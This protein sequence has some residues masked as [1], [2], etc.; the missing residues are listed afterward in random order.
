[1]NSDPHS[2]QNSFMSSTGFGQ[3]SMMAAP[4][5]DQPPPKITSARDAFVNVEGALIKQYGDA[6]PKETVFAPGMS[7][8]QL[9]P[10]TTNMET[11]LGGLVPG[12]MPLHES[13]DPS[14]KTT[15]YPAADRIGKT[16]FMNQQ[17]M[18]PPQNW[19]AVG[20]GPRSNRASPGMLPVANKD[21]GKYF[22]VDTLAGLR[23]R[24]EGSMSFQN[25]IY[26]FYIL[27]GLG[28]MF[29]VR[30]VFQGNS[31]N[32]IGV[33]MVLGA[34]GGAMYYSSTKNKEALV[35]SPGIGTGITRDVGRGKQ[36]Y[37]PLMRHESDHKPYPRPV[38][39][40]DT[41][42]DRM[43]RQNTNM[44]NV[45][46]PRADYGY[47]RGPTPANQRRLQEGELMRSAALYNMDEREFNEYMARLDGEAPD[48]FYQA[49][50]YL[51][52][53][54]HWDHKQDIADADTVHGIS[55]APGQAMRKSK[56]IDPRIQQAGAKTSHLKDPPPGSDQP[57]DKVHPWIQK[58]IETSASQQPF[59]MDAY[60]QQANFNRENGVAE[61]VSKQ[62]VEDLVR[63]RAEENL[64][65]QTSM[66]ITQRPANMPLPPGLQPIA[67]SPAGYEELK[68]KQQEEMSLFVDSNNPA[69]QPPK[70]QVDN[71][72]PPPMLL[73]T[74]SYTDDETRSEVG[75]PGTYERAN[76]SGS[77]RPRTGNEG[78]G[79]PP[80][81][82]E[83]NA[84]AEF[85][86]AFSIKNQPSP[87]AVEL[88]LQERGGR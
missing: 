20:V 55:T 60:A 8:S 6:G 56:Y 78:M 45:E 34:A 24:A 53:S 41:T 2:A 80:A 59:S 17:P 10:Y 81:S 21:Q 38:D 13:R 88:A 3:M 25:L 74:E 28:A 54:A 63:L 19:S 51:P 26:V 75:G 67:T 86:G 57:I 58:S 31:V 12:H 72:A 70:H 30:A 79:A 16:P 69:R 43:R 62:Q 77:G 4:V 11:P 42:M 46:G 37:K 7:S 83:E 50:A 48:Q 84:V 39:Y 33:I 15:P 52:F 64:A 66:G 18:M 40:A 73:Y 14:V 76:A 71:A 49:H 29:F 32:S 47:K 35:A 9:S 36:I 68:K 27:M 65:T 1:M 61:K 5:A 23:E 85:G 44:D 87:Q 82:T 22:S